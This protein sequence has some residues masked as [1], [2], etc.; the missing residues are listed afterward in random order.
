MMPPRLGRLG[1][2]TSVCYELLLGG[3]QAPEAGAWVSIKPDLA[4]QVAHEP[5]HLR[6][7]DEAGR[8]GEA[9]CEDA[10]GQ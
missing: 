1:T 2:R 8:S 9:S 5:V 10:L 7:V 4:R 3:A 6:A